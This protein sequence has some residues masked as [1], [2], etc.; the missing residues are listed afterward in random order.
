MTNNTSSLKWNAS[1]NFVGLGYTTLIG[2]VVLPLYLQYLGA[3]AFGLVGFFLVLQAW[4]QIFDLGMSP[5]LSR[6]TA[7]ARGKDSG[8]LELRRLLRSLELIVVVVA[9]LV[10]S[11]MAGGSSWISDNWLKVTSLETDI[12]ANCIVLMGVIV[13]FR[14]FVSL[15][16]SG[17]QGLEN[18]VR[19]NVINIF[20]VTLKFAGA[21]LLLKFLTQEITHFFIY[22]LAVGMLELTILMT[23]FYRCIPTTDKVG[24]AIY[25]SS[26]K[27]V[28]PFAAGMAYTA[29][30]WVIMTQLDKLVLSNILP[31]SEYGYFSLV[32]VVAAGISQIGSPISQAILPRMTYLLSQG[33]EQGM[34]LLYRQSTQ[35][36]AAIILPLTA[37]IAFFSEELLF[38][39]T[40]DKDAAEWAGPVLFWFALGNGVLAIAAFQFYLQFAHGKLKM[41]VIFNSIAAAVQIPL[42]V[43][44]AYKYGVMA[45][46]VTWFVLRLVSFFIWTPIVHKK[47]ARGIHWSWLFGDIGPSFMMTLFLLIMVMGLSIPF[48]LMNRLTIIAVLIGIGL[49]MLLCNTL[50]SRAPRNLLI[51][52]IMKRDSNED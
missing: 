41:H 13:S 35:L 39:W 31:L 49:L 21:L 6:Q 46:A 34:V 37:I 20:L 2:V 52:T 26:L 40:G 25:W 17:V 7:Q 16:R 30:I 8:Y 19:L 10:F 18:Q 9:L 12:V 5:L 14:F 43:Y 38:A 24:I 22:Q 42:I 51:G 15:Y 28:L 1:A 50:V 44:A 23:M 45:V 33:N 48:E 4:M 47:F 29:A 3:E 27:P 32:A 36:M 11:A